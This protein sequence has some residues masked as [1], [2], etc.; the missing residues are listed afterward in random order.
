MPK[1]VVLYSR[2]CTSLVVTFFFHFSSSTIN[3]DGTGRDRKTKRTVESVY[4]RTAKTTLQTSSQST[5]L[6]P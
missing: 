4:H 1:T 3:K 2:L 6:P 5:V